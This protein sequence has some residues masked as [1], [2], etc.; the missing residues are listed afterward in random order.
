MSNISNF[1][2]T[3]ERNLGTCEHED[4]EEISYSMG[5]VEHVVIFVMHDTHVYNDCDDY[6]IH[7]KIKMHIRVMCVSN[8]YQMILYY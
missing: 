4:D 6:H 3:R 1:Q 8:M 2:D 7:F 5:K